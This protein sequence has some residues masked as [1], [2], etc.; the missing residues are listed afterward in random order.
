MNSTVI[1]WC[2]IAA[3]LVGALLWSA[4]MHHQAAKP[5]GKHHRHFVEMG[6]DEDIFFVPG[7]RDDN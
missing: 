2:V 6:T 3:L 7:D 4:V 1:I 5:A